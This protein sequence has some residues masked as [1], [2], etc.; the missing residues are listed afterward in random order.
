LQ[1][2]PFPIIVL[3]FLLAG[4]GGG[5]A[6][7]SDS[8]GNRTESIYEDVAAEAGL[9]FDHFIGAT[10]ERYIIE[11]MGAG[12]ALLDYD[13]DGDLDAFFLQGNILTP[14]KTLA[15]ST[16]PLRDG[17]KLG[18]RFFRNELVP[19]GSL[20]FTDVTSEAGLEHIGYGMGAATGDYDNDG[21]ID[22]YVSNFG[23][24]ILYENNGDGTFADV[25]TQSGVGDERWGSSAA[26]L[27]YDHDGDLDL[28]VANY[29]D[30]TFQGN[31]KCYSP[32]GELDYCTPLVYKGA[33][34]K[35]WRNDGGRKW[36]DV[37]VESNIASAFGPGLG[38][39]TT[40]V[41]GDG[42]TD[43]YIAND[44]AANL[45]WINQ[46]DG[47]FLETGLEAGVAYSEDGMPKAGMGVSFGDFDAD[48]D[49]DLIV[50][51]LRAEG[52]SLYLNEGDGYFTDVTLRFGLGHMTYQSTG[53]GID[54]FDYDGD[55]WLDIFM[56]NGAVTI[57][58]ELID[59]PY[60]FDQ[61]NM[62]LRN[63]GTGNSFDDVSTR[64]GPALAL[65]DVSRGAAF[66]DVDNDGDVDILVHNNNGPPRLLL[67]EVGNRSNWMTIELEGTKTNRQG[68]GSRVGLVRD[69]KPTLWRRAHTDSSYCSAS[70]AKVH[71]GLGDDSARQTI[72]VKWT[73]GSTERWEDLA[74]NENTILKQGTGTAQQPDA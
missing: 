71:I 31:K 72:V 41:D 36:T 56:A 43:I 22:L 19:S 5:E 48:G 54:W 17:Q 67:N 32:A 30:F 6:P 46:G 44:T 51:N 55:G 13:N 35:L 42:L 45:L 64:S 61:P 70:D 65:R 9:A 37:S 20:H 58:E 4:C 60:P 10:G 18:N 38:I 40:D 11:V 1:L 34:D 26:F 59:D 21:D 24:N 16:F 39:T 33:V 12:C 62:L 47:T 69:G 23:P 14:G 74:V 2:H 63:L 7:S 66:G 68:L 27:D 49:D 53:F 28:M 52:C 50:L 8:A 25:T 57:I 3:L 73:D 15:D 29:V